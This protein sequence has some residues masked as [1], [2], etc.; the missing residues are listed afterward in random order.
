MQTPMLARQQASLKY[1]QISNFTSMEKLKGTGR[2]AARRIA[3]LT[4]IAW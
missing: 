1:T 3:A 4:E 2:G